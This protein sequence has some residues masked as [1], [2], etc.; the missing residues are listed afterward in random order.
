MVPGNIV[1]FITKKVAFC[2]AFLYI[3]TQ[4]LSDEGETFPHIQEESTMSANQRRRIAAIT[5]IV[6]QPEAAHQKINNILHDFAHL[7]VGRMGIPYRERG[8]SI[9]S[10]IVDGDNDAIGAMTGSLG[11]IPSVTVKSAFAKEMD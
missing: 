8:L 6:Y 1:I 2:C 9:I 10:L 3:V 5:I 4:L 7:I 11:Q